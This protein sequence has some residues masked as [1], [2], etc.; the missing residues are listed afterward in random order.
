MARQVLSVICVCLNN[1]I[2]VCLW[3]IILSLY[4]LLGLCRPYRLGQALNSTYSD[5]V[6]LSIGYQLN[7]RNG[8]NPLFI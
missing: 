7:F 5:N 8:G 4:V 6:L 1:F 2:Y 3:Y